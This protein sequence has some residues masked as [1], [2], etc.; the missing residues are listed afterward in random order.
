MAA[1]SHQKGCKG[2]LERCFNLC[3]AARQTQYYESTFLCRGQLQ[4]P[5]AKFTD[6]DLGANIKTVELKQFCTCIERA[7]EII[8]DL[9]ARCRGTLNV[10]ERRNCWY[11]AQDACDKPERGPT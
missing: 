8:R 7:A 5:L 6:L 9:R 11:V 2:A 4:H 10:N 3:R 1:S